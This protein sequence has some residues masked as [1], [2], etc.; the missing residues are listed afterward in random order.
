MDTGSKKYLYLLAA[1]ATAGVV[2]LFWEFLT[3]YFTAED[4]T[5][6]YLYHRMP[7]IELF[8]EPNL[9]AVVVD[10]YRPVTDLI[11]YIETMLFG[12]T[13]WPWHAVNILL[14]LGNLFF[15]YL[16]AKPVIGS[17]GAAC[18]V[19]LFAWHPVLPGMLSFNVGG[20]QCGF[21][22]LFTLLSMIYLAR[23]RTER[24]VGTLLLC[25]L[26]LGLAV[27]SYEWFSLP[28]VLIA[29]DFCLPRA[30]Q[31]PGR[32]KGLLDHLPVW[33]VFALL[34]LARKA[35][36]GTFLGGYPLTLTPAYLFKIPTAFCRSI[37]DY[38]L[39]PAMD[40]LA[41]GTPVLLGGLAAAII[42]G[43]P[44]L[45]S[46]FRRNV[47]LL[48]LMFLLAA[49]PIALVT[50]HDPASARRF[51]LPIGF[52]AMLAGAALTRGVSAL[53]PRS[54]AAPVP[55]ILS[56]IL[57]LYYGGI[58]LHISHHYL[59]AG[60]LTK[61]IQE[62]VLEFVG[63]AHDPKEPVIL[64]NTP[65][66]V[67]VPRAGG[68]RT[69]AVAKVF[70][71]GL[72]MAFSPPFSDRDLKVY[73]VNNAPCFREENDVPFML[74]I[75]SEGKVLRF[76]ERM[77]RV[78]ELYY[79]DRQTRLIEYMHKYGF[80]K[81]PTPLPVKLPCTDSNLVMWPEPRGFPVC[82]NMRNRWSEMYRIAIL[83]QHYPRFFEIPKKA[84]TAD[85]IVK[86][87]KGS[88]FNIKITDPGIRDALVYFNR[89]PVFLWVE[90]VDEEGKIFNRSELIRFRISLPEEKED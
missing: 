48:L 61:M 19:L 73:P 59:R 68:G 12:A 7:F 16:A 62:Q 51:Y 4:F 41:T 26:F 57:A 81:R 30:E 78:R 25:A 82:F 44:F 31:G 10:L 65:M 18:G 53:L 32:F 63:E 27:G 34:L 14:H 11:I 40:G 43:I 17:R 3:L 60:R 52:L 33:L 90:A 23:F 84:I 85:Q 67:N 29:Y 6:I 87:G 72:S 76:D 5:F 55:L 70:Q 86:D 9:K 80:G 49:V 21:V 13:A 1:L 47:I 22:L 56:L 71:F 83:T 77:D 74:Y 66:T 54:R 8:T 2:F 46:F 38:G 42:L 39:N 20:I 75:R 36:L 35:V 79:P 64:L 89:E 28:L 24:K 50:S 37:W 15:L 69:M 58:T 88:K 45:L